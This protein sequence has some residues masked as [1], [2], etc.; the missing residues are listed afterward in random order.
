MIEQALDRPVQNYVT[1]AK[2]VE[3]I[4]DRFFGEKLPPEVIAAWENVAATMC[5]VDHM[6]DNC[7]NRQQRLTLERQ[8]VDF[9]QD[10][11]PTCPTEDSALKD[12]LQQLR[13]DLSNLPEDKRQAFF[14][15]LKNIFRVTERI[16]TT[17]NPHE[18]LELTRLEGQLAGRFLLVFLPEEY[19]Q[20]K[21][22]RT[23]HSAIAKL[24]RA[25]NTMDAFLDLPVDY[26]GGQILVSPSPGTRLTLLKSSGEELFSAGFAL[27]QIGIGFMFWLGVRAVKHIREAQKLTPLKN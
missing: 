2:G 26:S 25:S 24:G 14:R 21:N 17:T 27:R 13:E 7:S 3:L 11:T 6:I 19:R 9:L 10:A 16:K 20:R 12:H 18:L 23:Y 22:Y 5:L 1:L 15:S 4:T 8:T